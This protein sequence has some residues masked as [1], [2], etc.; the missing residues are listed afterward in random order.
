MEDQRLAEKQMLK[1]ETC[2]YTAE[3]KQVP[4]KYITVKIYSLD[5]FFRDGQL[6]QIKNHG[7]NE[8]KC[9]ELIY[10]YKV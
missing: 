6:T 5:K 2:C 7:S 8:L 1:A 10:R 9:E 4:G 3:V